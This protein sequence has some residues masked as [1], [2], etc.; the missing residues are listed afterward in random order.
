[1]LNSFLGLLFYILIARSLGPPAFGLFIVYI[2]LSILFSE[3]GDW[4]VVS[5]LIKFSQGGQFLSQFF[6]AVFLHRLVISSVFLLGGI[7]SSFVFG[8]EY[9]QVSLTAISFLFL[10]MV[11]YS[12]IARGQ[13]FHFLM[14]NITSNIARLLTT[15][16]ILTRFSPSPLTWL[17]VYLTVNFLTFLSA[18]AFL[19]KIHSE[20]LFSKEQIVTQAKKLLRFSS[21]LGG[22]FSIASIMAKTDVPLIYY[23]G[24][25][26]V[27]GIYAS[28]SRLASIVPLVSSA[29]DNVFVSKFSSKENIKV[30]FRD[31]LFIVI[32]I[33]ALLILGLPFY[34]SVILYLLGA[35]YVG[36]I[37]VFKYLVIGMAV[38]ILT[39]PFTC[40]LTY[41][42][43]RPKVQFFISALQLV[44]LFGLYT[45]LISNMGLLGIV[46]SFII[47]QIITFLIYFI[48]CWKSLHTL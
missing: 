14:I 2:N 30:V 27:S 43:S 4:G 11:T 44:I 37:W 3:I 7:L 42:Q 45:F 34:D 15:V 6:P 13:Y 23:L 32:L 12:F 28:A 10:S 29:L 1:M 18:F 22:S 40:Y 33:A 48:L 25:A 46:I 39:A 21:W 19:I 17:S 41:Y 38:F 36:S 9:F 26:A 31:Y 35:Q 5:G 24:G 16:I 8:Y 47:S 20:S